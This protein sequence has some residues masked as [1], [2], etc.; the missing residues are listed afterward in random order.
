[1]FW[2]SLLSTGHTPPPPPHHTTP[3]VVLGCSPR[4]ELSLALFQIKV[5]CDW[6]RQVKGLPFIHELHAP[7]SPIALALSSSSLGFS[8]CVCNRR[9][10]HQYGNEYVRCVLGNH[11][12]C[13]PW[14]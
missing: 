9:W 2:T 8:F 6:C 11:S 14:D 7:P 4:R 3:V 5:G 13:F 10:Q 1:M 12:H